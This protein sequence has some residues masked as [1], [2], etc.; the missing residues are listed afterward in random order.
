V[1]RAEV[2]GITLDYEVEGSGPPLVL[3]S[4]LGGNRNGW[5]LSKPLFLEDHTVITF[6]NRGT[7]RSDVPPGPY[8]M[9]D[10]ADDTAALVKHLDLG[11]VA[12]VGVSMGGLVT[13]S[14]LINHP[15]VLTKAVLLSTFPSYTPIQNPWLDGLL[16]LRRA[17]ADPRV[18][19]A[20]GLPWVLTAKSLFDHDTMAANIELMV[21]D[22]H[23]TSLEGFEAQAHGT[24]H[25]NSLDDLHKVTTPT[26]VLVGAEDVL[27]PP[28][29]S[30]QIAERIPGAE[31]QILP[32][33]NHGMIGE[34]MLETVTAIRAWL[35][36]PV[37][38]TA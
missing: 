28:F 31:L 37:A 6:D 20:I 1:A 17:G 35:Q 11:P 22:P 32:R 25:F 2:N 18:L 14:L 9:D 7:G 23:P 5:A 13:Q 8:S 36:A 3:I 27:T 19:A 21:S 30:V 29:Q 24:R 33:G 10:L 26:L 12:A 4:G 16:E 38:A 34:Y 15:D